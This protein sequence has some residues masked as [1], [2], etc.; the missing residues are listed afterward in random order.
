[1]CSG[2]LLAHAD[3]CCAVCRLEGVQQLRVWAQGTD[4]EIGIEI[5]AEASTRCAAT[6][7][8]YPTNPLRVLVDTLSCESACRCADALVVN[9]LQIMNLVAGLVSF[10]CTAL[11]V[12]VA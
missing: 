11:P 4:G 2:S 6:S 7:H 3:F 5:T 1:M 9:L 12:K 10:K 8:S